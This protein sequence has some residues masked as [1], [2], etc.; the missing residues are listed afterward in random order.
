[1]RLNY[2]LQR[3]GMLKS[4]LS[5]GEDTGRSFANNAQKQSPCVKVLTR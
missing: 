5:V 1:M 3:W 4:W 2:P